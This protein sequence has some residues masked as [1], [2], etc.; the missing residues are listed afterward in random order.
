MNN[1]SAYVHDPAKRCS[2]CSSLVKDNY[3]PYFSLILGKTAINPLTNI[4]TLCVC[5][6]VC[7][8]VCIANK[9]GREAGGTQTSVPRNHKSTS[10]SDD[11]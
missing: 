1:K 11:V 7:V 3:F 2:N 6:C 5:V 8:C 10:I 9:I 4:L